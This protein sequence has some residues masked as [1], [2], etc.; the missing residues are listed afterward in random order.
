MDVVG[1]GGGGPGLLWVGRA[2]RRDLPDSTQHTP[3]ALEQC[4]DATRPSTPHTHRSLS[5]HASASRRSTVWCLLCCLLKLITCPTVAPSSMCAT[6]S[7][8][9]GSL[10]VTACE[11]YR[12]DMSRPEMARL[13]QSMVSMRRVR[14]EICSL[15][16]FVGGKKKRRTRGIVSVS[17]YYP[18]RSVDVG[19]TRTLPSYSLEAAPGVHGDD[20]PANC[21][22]PSGRKGMSKA[23]A[24]PMYA[25]EPRSW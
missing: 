6:L 16:L 5:A 17:V 24:L 7:M 3:E 20:P 4:P 1:G 8:Y 10:M 25:S 22:T 12:R 21:P 19:S 14:I 2:T 15:K 23:A 13:T 18:P 9:N 11:V